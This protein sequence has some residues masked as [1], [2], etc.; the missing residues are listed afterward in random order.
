MVT[1]TKKKKNVSRK[2][3][4]KSRKNM[5]G[6]SAPKFEVSVPKLPKVPNYELVKQ[7]GHEQNKASRYSMS[8]ISKEPKTHIDY[9]Q[10]YLGEKNRLERIN[11]QNIMDLHSRLSVNPHNL[12]EQ[13]RK[14]LL[15]KNGT[16]SVLNSEHTNYLPKVLSRLPIEDVQR[17]LSGNNPESTPASAYENSSKFLP[18][19]ISNSRKSVYE[20][21]TGSFK[22]TT[23]GKANSLSQSIKSNKSDK[24]AESVYSS[25]SDSLS[26]SRKSTGSTGST[27]ESIYNRLSQNNR[28]NFRNSQKSQESIYGVKLR[29]PKQNQNAA[30]QNLLLSGDKGVFSRLMGAT[31]TKK[32]GFLGLGKSTETTNLEKLKQNLTNK[33]PNLLK[34]NK[35]NTKLKELVETAKQKHAE[36]MK[37]VNLIP[38]EINFLSKMFAETKGEKDV[39]DVPLSKELTKQLSKLSGENRKNNTKFYYSKYRQG[40]PERQ[41]LDHLKEKLEKYKEKVKES[42]KS[43]H[44]SKFKSKMPDDFIMD[45]ERYS[46]ENKYHKAATDFAVMKT[47]DKFNLTE[48]PSDLEELSVEQRKTF[49]NSYDNK[50]LEKEFLEQTEKIKE[51]KTRPSQL[52]T[53]I[54]NPY[55]TKNNLS[56]YYEDV[57]QYPDLVKRVN[58]LKRKKN[59][60]EEAKKRLLESIEIGK[61]KLKN[62]IAEIKNRKNTKNY[63]NNN[64]IRV[65]ELEMQ[66]K[67]LEL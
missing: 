9:I 18:V 50:I 12:E 25:L 26:G 36:I 28:S 14:T 65:E 54:E 46:T 20:N 2:K 57:N 1:L 49:N 21:M 19:V 60:P 11:T 53:E 47:L 52:P 59:L 56:S 58:I 7:P 32:T 31:N 61:E 62:L 38:E 23:T 55:G 34:N 51:N 22:K 42:N 16:R 27:T 44:V 66:L 4:F 33:N 24:S 5:R 41:Y 10:K 6:G 30:V 45:P 64:I 3:N 63:N 8:N 39:K 48:F 29:T 37:E 17:I 13:I 67:D 43:P 15:S 40:S 35:N